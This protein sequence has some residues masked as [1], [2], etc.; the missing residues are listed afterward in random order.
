[1]IRLLAGTARGGALSHDSGVVASCGDVGRAMGQR[2]ARDD[3]NEPDREGRARQWSNQ[4][5]TRRREPI[6]EPS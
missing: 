6:E 4:R 5:A 3:E 1:M 2:C